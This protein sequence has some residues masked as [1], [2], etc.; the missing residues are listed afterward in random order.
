MTTDPIKEVKPR[1]LRSSHQHYCSYC[2]R[3]QRCGW[4]DCRLRASVS[5]FCVEHKTEQEEAAARVSATSPQTE[6]S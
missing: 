5:R 1:R 4:D 2:H 6:R 3:W